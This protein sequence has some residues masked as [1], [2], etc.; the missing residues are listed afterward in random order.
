MAIS[1][2]VVSPHSFVYEPLPPLRLII[3]VGQLSL[4]D[5]FCL[6]QLC[7]TCV[8]FSADFYV[9]SPLC[10]SRTTFNPSTSCSWFKKITCST[11]I[12][13]DSG[14][15]E[16]QLE[17]TGQ[18]GG[19]WSHVFSCFLPCSI[20]LGCLYWRPLFSL[21]FRFCSPWALCFCTTVRGLCHSQL[22]K[23]VVYKYRL[24][25]LWEAVWGKVLFSVHVVSAASF[26]RNLLGLSRAVG[27]LYL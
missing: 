1:S 13:G 23:V 24:L 10:L 6:P 12:S 8:H 17:R 5:P 25:S 16:A 26:S 22:I 20:I 27:L 9:R 19:A 7:Q 18:G 21:G 4:P 11:L 3:P 14:C 2:T 15:W